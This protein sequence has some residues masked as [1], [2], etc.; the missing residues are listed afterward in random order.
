MNEQGLEKQT[1]PTVP[2]KYIRVFD[3]EQANRRYREEDYKVHSVITTI[4]QEDL[5]SRI[6]TDISYL[7][8]LSSEKTY[9]NITNLIDITPDQVD[10]YLADGWIVADSWSKLV[11]M[12]KKRVEANAEGGEPDTI[13]VEGN[14]FGEEPCRQR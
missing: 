2:L 6:M 8:S 3:I 14:G 5:S 10:A 11:R 7:M 4:R 13:P 9:D 1:E 12:V